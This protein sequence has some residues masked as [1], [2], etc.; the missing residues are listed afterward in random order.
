M[1]L[2]RNKESGVLCKTSL[3]SVNNLYIAKTEDN[4]GQIPMEH[5]MQ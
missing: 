5:H 1:E 2:A 3:L 4:Q